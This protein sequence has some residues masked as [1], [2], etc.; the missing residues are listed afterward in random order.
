MATQGNKNACV[1]RSLARGSDTLANPSLPQI[2]YT[3]VYIVT[4]NNIRRRLRSH[5]AKTM[6]RMRVKRPKRQLSH[7]FD[8]SCEGA[9]PFSWVYVLDIGIPSISLRPLVFGITSDRQHFTSQ[10]KK[11]PPSDVNTFLTN[12]LIR[13][14]SNYHLLMGFFN[15]IARISNTFCKCA[16]IKL[17]NEFQL[18]YLYSFINLFMTCLRCRNVYTQS[19]NNRRHFHNNATGYSSKYYSFNGINKLKKNI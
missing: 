1:R 8:V 6:C 2:T 12:V 9:S 4:T 14:F 19:S 13:S 3:S 5:R 7:P 15:T 17:L 16:Y 10:M 18:I 11:A